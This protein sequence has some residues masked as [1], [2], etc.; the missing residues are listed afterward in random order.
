LGLLSLKPSRA[1]SAFQCSFVGLYFCSFPS[2][3]FKVQGTI[4]SDL[5]LLEIVLS[6]D[7]S[8]SVGFRSFSLDL[9]V[10][11]LDFCEVAFYR[12]IDD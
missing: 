3:S 1:F 4:G 6:L 11:G 10:C 9:A 7:T 2:T 8:V 5:S 12:M